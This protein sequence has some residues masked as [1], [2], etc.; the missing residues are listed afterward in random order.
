MGDISKK[1]QS[2]R[3][4]LSEMWLQHSEQLREGGAFDLSRRHRWMIIVTVAV[5]VTVLR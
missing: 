5:S 1:Q 3:Q 4:R 2:I